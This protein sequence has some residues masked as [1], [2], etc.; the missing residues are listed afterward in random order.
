MTPIGP[1][2]QVDESEVMNVTD[3]ATGEKTRMRRRKLGLWSFKNHAFANDFVQGAVRNITLVRAGL[4]L[5]G[6]VAGMLWT[7][8]WG[9]YTY[10]IEPRQERMISSAIAEALAPIS[11]RIDEDERLFR[12]HLYDIERQRGLF[13][14]KIEL[15]EDMDEIKAAL[16]RLEERR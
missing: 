3:R 5:L 4:G 11:R 1:D 10:V 14:T 6:V 7:I 13:P 2:E 12:E 15:K 16:I 9:T 8:I